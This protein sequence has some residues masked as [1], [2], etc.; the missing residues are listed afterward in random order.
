MKLRTVALSM[1][2]A[3]TAVGLTGCN[4]EAKVEG[5]ITPQMMADNLHK[6]IDSDRTVYTKLIVGRLAAKEK[7]IKADEHWEDKKAL[8][9]PAQMLRYGSEMV[10]ERNADFTYSLQ[11]SW[12][13][14]KQNAPRTPM[15]KEGLKFIEQNK[16]QNFY[17]TETLGDKKY[18][19]AI[20]P[21]FAA[22]KVCVTCHNEHKDSPKTDFKMGDVM[23]GLVIRIPL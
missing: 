12:P 6:V 11:S 15:E 17:G 7:V 8:V 3:A 5:A 19:T 1:G 2:L 16:G 18:F 4:E 13:I 9:L 23:G 10:Q 21:D 14:N 22:V 20:Y